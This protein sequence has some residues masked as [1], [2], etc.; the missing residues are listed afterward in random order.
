MEE[1]K[2]CDTCGAQIDNNDK[3][4][5]ECGKPIDNTK[6]EI[7]EKNIE[8]NEEIKN[9]KFYQKQWFMWVMLVLFPPV[10][11]FLLWYFN[12]TFKRDAKII[13]T[14]CFG[15]FWFMSSF[16]GSNEYEDTTNN[17]SNEQEEIKKEE[18]EE[19]KWLNYYKHNNIEYIEMDYKTLYDYGKYFVNKIVLT[20]A[21]ITDINTSNIEFSFDEN[22][23]Y[24]LLF[25]FENKNEIK[26]YKEGD[27][28]VIIGKVD[29]N[30]WDF[31]DTITLKECHVVMSKNKATTKNEELNNNK[32]NN[33]KVAEDIK[34]KFIKDEN[35]KLAAE[36]ETY[37]NK[38]SY[39]DYNSILRNPN[40]YKGQFVK[41]VGRVDQAE[42]GLFSM[43]HLFVIDDNGKKW[44]IS[45]S[46]EKYET[47]IFEGDRVSIYGELQGT[48]TYKTILGDKIT[49][50]DIS[51]KYIDIH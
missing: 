19:E 3:F 24:D 16:I 26:E 38:C 10:G 45:H 21:K 44:S 30:Y 4:C 6:T 27:I 29:D 25:E 34:N 49:L 11:I 15:M 36:K 20:S 17:N 8:R 50:P 18:T 2:Y 28:V 47:R 1:K 7:N 37:K 42:K 39:K 46:Y 13:L 48:D 14:I 35:D 31:V 43:V 33:K 51:S 9:K 40:S 23:S 22:D 12:K 41:V 5:R 32:E